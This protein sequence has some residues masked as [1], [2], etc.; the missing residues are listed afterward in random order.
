M[1][2]NFLLKFDFQLSNCQATY[3]GET[4][5]NLTTQLNKH[6]LATEKGDLN[7][8]IVELLLKTTHTINWDS[9]TCLNYSTDYY[10]RITLKKLVY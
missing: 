8:N 10:Q 3:I 5:R 2:H 4:S 9:A 1:S 6:K 7:D